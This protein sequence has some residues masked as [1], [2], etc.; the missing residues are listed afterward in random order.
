[1]LRPPSARSVTWTPR[2]G[3]CARSRPSV[4]SGSGSRCRQKPRRGR[5]ST[6]SSRKG[7]S[8]RRTHPTHPRGRST[9]SSMTRT[10]DLLG[11]P[12]R[13]VSRSFYLSLR[14]LP[15]DVREPIGL[16]YLLARAA[17]TVADTRLVPR[18][19]RVTHLETLRKA[20]GGG[21]ADLE[22][23]VTACAPHHPRAAE[24]HLLQ[25]TDEAVA[26]L[27][28]LP[29][30]DREAVRAVLSTLTSGMLFDLMRFPA[31]DA[32]GLA[33]LD[34]L[35]ELDHYIYLVAGCVGEFWTQLH[36]A[37]RP[38]LANWNRAT[39]SAEGVRFG[40]ALQ[41]TNVLRDVPAD[42]RQGRCYVPAAE[43]AA[44]GL[45]P[46]ELLDPGAAVRAQPLLRRLL[47]AAL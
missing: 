43:L 37:H 8:A 47:L 26:R 19:E 21:V 24:H 17:D 38:R 31:E 39:M 2:W 34:T 16:A 18:S 35:D 5:S 1:M 7:S 3:P 13:Q 40:K 41:M 30:A 42:L 45:T 28:A 33:A 20:F 14:V 10:D 6:A 12:L 15:R 25:R 46:R 27:G 9:S 36:M 22:R 4:R 44:L 29:A 32:S 23:V 11:D